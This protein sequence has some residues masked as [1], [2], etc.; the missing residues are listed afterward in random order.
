MEASAKPSTG[1]RRQAGRDDVT[2]KHTKAPAS[3]SHGQAGLMLHRPC[4]LV[5]GGDYADA[6]S[7]RT[8]ARSRLSSACSA[9]VSAPNAA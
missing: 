2:W 3:A 4:W 7:D 9:A 8:F 6:P 1:A 5:Q